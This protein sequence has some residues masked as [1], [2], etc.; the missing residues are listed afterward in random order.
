MSFPQLIV[1]LIVGVAAVY[2][3]RTLYDSARDLFSKKSE[4]CGGCGKCAFAEQIR[5]RQ[6]S[7]STKPKVIALSEI[8]TLPK[9]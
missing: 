7:A 8:Q 4:G 6:A 9:K 1:L 2:V 3:G 5:T